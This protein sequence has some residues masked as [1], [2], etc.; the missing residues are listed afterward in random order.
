MMEMYQHDKTGCKVCGQSLD[1]SPISGSVGSGG[2][3]KKDDVTLI[4][5]LL[6]AV[7]EIEGG[8]TE[9]LKIDGFSGPKTQDAISRFQMAKLKMQDGRI[10]ISNRSIAALL[11]CIKSSPL[12]PCGNLAPAKS[13]APAPATEKKASSVIEANL[14]LEK[15][16]TALGNLRWKFTR[17]TNIFDSWIA[18]HFTSG[19]E[20]ITDA[21]VS[22]VSKYVA[23]I[24]FL[25]ARRNTFGIFP[26][27]DILLTEND[28]AYGRTT[29]GGDKMSTSQIDIYKNKDGS[30]LKSPGHTVW[31]GNAF[32]NCNSQTKL[33]TLLHELAHYVGPRTSSPDKVFDYAY[34]FNAGFGTI[35]KFQKL[36]NAETIG[37]FLCEYVLGTESLPPIDDAPKWMTLFRKNPT[38][39]N[40]VIG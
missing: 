4:Q 24:H 23:D 40:R 7:P 20:K 30:I 17:R 25:M 18:K 9:V 14:I 11:D 36:R 5:K 28:P 6:N 35:P 32:D 19:H 16:S 29:Y 26:F 33:L 3:N 12:I 27:V 39:K 31:L 8:P 1:S 13:G 38:V 21:D 37:M 22:R 10:D 15:I 34:M 2:V